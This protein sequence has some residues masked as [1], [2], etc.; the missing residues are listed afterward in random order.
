MRVPPTGWSNFEIFHGPAVPMSN[1]SATEKS[2]QTALRAAAWSRRGEENVAAGGR[3]P[4][5]EDMDPNGDE[6]VTEEEFIQF[7]AVPYFG[8]VASLDGDSAC[9]SRADYNAY[10]GARNRTDSK[11]AGCNPLECSYESIRRAVGTFI[12][13]LVILCVVLLARGVCVIMLTRVF[14][15]S[16][17]PDHLKFP[18]WEGQI[19]VIQFLSISKISVQLMGLGIRCQP[20]FEIGCVLFCL[21]PVL[22][23]IV[24]LVYLRAHVDSEDFS[25]TRFKGINMAILKK[26]IAMSQI[27]IFGSVHALVRASSFYNSRGEWKY[28]PVRG[29]RFWQFLISSFNG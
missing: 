4:T 28:L 25:F 2:G 24:S 12:T 19:V 9:I 20:W 3:S 16:T 13:C 14:G 6:C 1:V 5:F 15:K 7:A 27:G 18:S 8:D 26:S 11:V 29:A 10:V 23:L 17:C 21:W 22:M